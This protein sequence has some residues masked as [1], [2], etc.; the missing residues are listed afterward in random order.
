MKWFRRPNWLGESWKQEMGRRIEAAESSVTEFKLQMNR[1][2]NRL[3][4]LEGAEPN[5]ED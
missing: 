3:V 4:K 5:A 1:V 2:D